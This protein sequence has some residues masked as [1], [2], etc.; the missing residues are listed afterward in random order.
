MSTGTLPAWPDGGPTRVPHWIYRD[1]QMYRRELERIFEGPTTC[2][3]QRVPDRVVFVDE[4]PARPSGKVRRFVLREWAL[5][6][7]DV[8]G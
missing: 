3:D 1:E 2:G 7:I 6:G 8:D 5:G 4:M